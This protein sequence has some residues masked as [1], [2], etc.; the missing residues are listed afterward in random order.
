MKKKSEDFDF[1]VFSLEAIERLRA[2]DS[3]VGANGILTPSTPSTNSN[4][5]GA[6]SS[7]PVPSMGGGSGMGQL[8]FQEMEENLGTKIDQLQKG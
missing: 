5:N 3:M 8:H 2:G 1:E 6:S 7:T 4:V